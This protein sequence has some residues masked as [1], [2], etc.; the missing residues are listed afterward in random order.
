MA[1]PTISITFNLCCYGSVPGVPGPWGGG[2]GVWG[3]AVNETS[4]PHVAVSQTNRPHVTVQRRLGAP[5]DA[6]H[7]I[8]T[9]GARPGGRTQPSGEGCR[10]GGVTELRRVSVTAKVKSSGG[11]ERVWGHEASGGAAAGEQERQEAV[12]QEL[13]RLTERAGDQGM[14]VYSLF[15]VNRIV[16]TIKKRF[17]VS[18]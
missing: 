9:R 12:R 13:G 1:P 17:L 14:S 6:R 18:F 2:G 10:G 11:H 5:N 3:R 7:Q 15:K 16:G 8:D 4:R